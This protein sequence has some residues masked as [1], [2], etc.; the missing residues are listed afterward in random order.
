M[1]VVFE[2]QAEVW[3]AEQRIDIIGWR[4]AKRIHKKH[5]GGCAAHLQQLSTSLCMV[6]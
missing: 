1:V 4:A 6:V 2:A 5:V 3:R